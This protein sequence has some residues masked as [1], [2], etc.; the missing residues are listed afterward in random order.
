MSALPPLEK[1]LRTPM[2]TA[3]LM[4]PT[5]SRMCMVVHFRTLQHLYSRICLI[6]HRLIRQFAQFLTFSLVPAELLSFVHI[7]VR[8]IRHR[9]I[10][11][12]AQFVASFYPEKRFVRLIHHLQ[13]RIWCLAVKTCG[14]SKK[15]R[16]FTWDLL[17]LPIY[18]SN[19]YTWCEARPDSPLRESRKSLKFIKNLKGARLNGGV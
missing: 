10:R 17:H 8:L 13:F 7:S 2:Q 6:R 19:F 9:L 1:F 11:Q 15:L 12:F 18:L 4:W 16:I 5:S 14:N 3:V